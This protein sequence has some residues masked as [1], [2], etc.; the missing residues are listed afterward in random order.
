MTS[1]DSRLLAGRVALVTGGDR[2]LGRDV[3]LGL[4]DHGAA[5]AVVGSTGAAAV[6]D[7]IL[8]A[9]GRAAAVVEDLARPEGARAAFG[10]AADTLGS[11]AVV[12]HAAVDA[13]ALESTPV[14]ALDA[15]SWDARG[16]RGLRVAIAC[17]QAAFEQLRARGGRIVFLTP[18]VGLTGAAGLAPYT[19]TLEGI[20]ALAKSAARQWGHLGI[21]VNCVAPALVSVSA[22]AAADPSVAPPALGRTP[23]GRADVAPVVAL[24]AAGAGHAVTG[25]TIVVDGGIVMAP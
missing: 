23:D 18:T 3:A 17:A 8:A 7:E 22:S 2:G 24:L 5:V 21:T 13:E 11:L 16:E 14:A 10:A 20:R 1:S 4:A 9:G 6:A 19:A 15:E 25:A 12:V